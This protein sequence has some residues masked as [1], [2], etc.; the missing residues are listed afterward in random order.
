MAS[1]AGELFDGET[2]NGIEVPLEMLTV[3]LPDEPMIVNDNPFDIT[4]DADRLTA[5]FT[6][7]RS[8]NSFNRQPRPHALSIELGDSLPPQMTEVEHKASEEQSIYNP[9]SKRLEIV[10]PKAITEPDLTATSL[11][12]V[13]ENGI[14]SQLELGLRHIRAIGRLDIRTS[15]REKLWLLGGV[16]TGEVSGPLLLGNNST[17]LP[18]LEHATTGAVGVA[19]TVGCVAVGKMLYDEIKFDSFGIPARALARRAYSQLSQEPANDK[20]NEYF[21]EPIIS[22]KPAAEA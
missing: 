2:S 18:L 9:V 1:M 19:V 15:E 5:A 22:L 4:L 14:N 17:L 7:L 11:A 10:T 13:A 12:L 8:E 21:K 16:M 3:F 6:F 20:L